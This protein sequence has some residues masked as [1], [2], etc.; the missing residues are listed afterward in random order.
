MQTPQRWPSASAAARIRRMGEWAPG[1]EPAVLLPDG[2]RDWFHDVRSPERPLPT[3]SPRPAPSPPSPECRTPLA[4]RL[5]HSPERPSTP[6]R[7]PIL[8]VRGRS[9]S[10]D[11]STVKYHKGD[12]QLPLAGSEVARLEL[13]VSTLREEL[14]Q[15]R[16]LRANLEKQAPPLSSKSS[17]LS[18]R[19]ERPDCR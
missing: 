10:Q 9:P 14:A 7:T 1:R 18:G 3:Q 15:E 12:A 13:E 4:R 2:S 17:R 8:R 5:F 19:P 11:R 16:R 6:I